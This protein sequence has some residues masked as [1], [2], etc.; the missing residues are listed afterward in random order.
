MQVFQQARAALPYDMG[1]LLGTSRVSVPSSILLFVI[2]GSGLRTPTAGRALAQTRTRGQHFLLVEGKM[3]DEY[4]IENAKEMLLRLEKRSTI[5]SNGCWIWKGST[6][7]AGYGRIEVGSE[8]CYV[9]RISWIISR[10]RIIPEGMLII[11]SCDNPSC[12]RPD[13]LKLGTNQSNSDDK[14]HKGR[15]A[16][17][18]GE[19]NSRA[20]LTWTIVRSIRKMY[21]KK[22]A[23]HSD[24]ASMYGVSRSTI[25]QIINN[26]IWQEQDYVNAHVSHSRK[27]V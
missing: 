3:D 17:L 21:A 8:N 5:D 27:K 2:G 6:N 4:I 13:H 24:F 14:V 20:I 11:H 15:Q 18:S 19:S 22:L 12:W 16:K 9:H 10:K 25:T 26:K 7:Q 1:Q 23:S